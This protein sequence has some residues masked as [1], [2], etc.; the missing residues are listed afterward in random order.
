[1]LP[2]YGIPPPS[3]ISTTIDDLLR[4]D[5]KKNSNN[6]FIADF[7][8]DSITTSF[9][10]LHSKLNYTSQDPSK[11]TDI[12]CPDENLKYFSGRDSSRSSEGQSIASRN[13]TLDNTST[14]YEGHVIKSSDS[15]SAADHVQDDTLGVL[16]CFKQSAPSLSSSLDRTGSNGH[17]TILAE[18]PTQM[19]EAITAEDKTLHLSRLMAERLVQAA[20]MAGSKDNVTVMIVLFSGSSIDLS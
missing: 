12:H 14:A 18:S 5:T 11:R 6:A 7:E 19:A 17:R 16:E 4:G 15:I 20:L 8:E 2:C 13:S 1:M 10:S 9:D 3:I